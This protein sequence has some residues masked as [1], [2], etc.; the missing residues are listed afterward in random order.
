MVRREGCQSPHDEGI[1]EESGV[2]V[3]DEAGVGVVVV[4]DARVSFRGGTGLAREQNRREGKRETRTRKWRQS[5]KG[6]AVQKGGVGSEDRGADGFAAPVAH[7]PRRPPPPPAPAP[8]GETGCVRVVVTDSPRGAARA[9]MG[10]SGEI[11]AGDA[12]RIAAAAGLGYPRP[13][14]EKTVCGG[15]GAAAAAG[16]RA[17]EG[18]SGRSEGVCF[19]LPGLKRG[20][21]GR[22]GCSCV[23]SGGLPIYISNIFAELYPDEEDFREIVSHQRRTHQRGTR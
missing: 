14:A 10:D 1:T 18:A 22:E 17:F 8:A 21:G 12:E 3:V 16:T 13:S 7:Q 5:Q 6:L 11:E 9:L 19:L 20:E 15:M 2:W 23:G 4:A